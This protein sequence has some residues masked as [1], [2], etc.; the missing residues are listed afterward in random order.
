MNILKETQP[1]TSS[2][3]SGVDE[4]VVM[5]RIRI[6]TDP[7]SWVFY[8]ALNLIGAELLSRL[9]QAKMDAAGARVTKPSRSLEFNHSVY[10]YTVSE[11]RPALAAVQS[12][13]MELNLLESAQVAWNDPREGVYRLVH[14]KSGEFQMP[15][16]AERKAE[17]DF[18]A[19]VNQMADKLRGAQKNDTS[20]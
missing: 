20:G 15:S 5:V 8:P 4:L 19:V 11:L 2:N 18:M 14:P 13:L 9:L 17:A 1:P 7:I 3:P 10:I 12:E 6:H 16:E